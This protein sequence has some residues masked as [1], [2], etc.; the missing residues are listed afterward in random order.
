[1]IRKQLSYFLI[2]GILASILN[3]I[4]VFILVHLNIA[5]P[6]VANF[7][8][9]LIAFN[10]SYFGHR[11]LTFSGTTKSHK[12]AGSQ[13]FI[14]A[15]IGLALNEGIYFILLHF[16]IQYLVALFITMVLVALYTFIISKLFIFTS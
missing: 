6:L 3:F 4:I 13:F 14:N 11:Y 9:F 10:V 15:L 7:F 16:N 5:K 8:A 1:M 12:K 2:I